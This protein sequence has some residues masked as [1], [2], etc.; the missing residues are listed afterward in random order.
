MTQKQLSSVPGERTEHTDSCGGGGCSGE[1]CATM[2][3]PHFCGFS[4]GTDVVHLAFWHLVVRAPVEK[5][6]VF[7]VSR[8]RKAKLGNSCRREWRNPGREEKG[9]RERPLHLP[10]HVSGW[11]M[12]RVHSG[13]MKQLS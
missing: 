10:A 9:D 1:G 13:A 7:L 8:I 6:T 4:S 2:R 3:V 5:P 11:P 12:N